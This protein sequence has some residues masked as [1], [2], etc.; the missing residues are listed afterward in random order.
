[1]M[2]KI[3]EVNTRLIYENNDNRFIWESPYSDVSMEDILN[4][5]YG[6]LVADTWLPVT[7]IECMKDF[8]DEHSYLLSEDNDEDNI[9]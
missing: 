8:V 4:A 7:V 9:E 6:I 5:L 3:D 1:M 2:N